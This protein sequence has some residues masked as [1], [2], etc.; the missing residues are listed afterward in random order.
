MKRHGYTASLAMLLLLWAVAP[1]RAQVF[2]GRIDLSIDDATGGRLPGVT[3]DL[4]GPVNQSQVSDAQGQSHFLNL[5][6]GRYAVKTTLT[7]FNAYTNDNVIVAAGSSTPLNVRLAVA[8][9]TEN[10][11][12]T[13]ATPIID[14]KR[15]TTTTNVTLEELQNIPT[16]RDPWVVM[17]TVPTITVDRVNV[18]GS[19]SGQQ[20]VYIAKGASGDR[21]H[22]EHR[23]RADHRHGVDRLVPDLFRFRHVPGDGDHDGRRRR[24][25]LHARRA[26][27]PRPQEGHERR[28]WRWPLLLRESE[29]AGNQHFTGHGP[30]A[31]EHHRQRQPHGSLRRQRLRHRRPHIQRSALGLGHGGPHRRP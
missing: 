24:T 4:T 28:A 8:G 16:A 29:S 21:Q 11:V 2:T 26:V 13:A 5:P 1:A 31:W 25:E 18:G 17:Q 6:P 19:E 27:E 30:A 23:R 3:V 15:Q 9:T 7:G 12:V 10:V 22:V 20:S 14:P